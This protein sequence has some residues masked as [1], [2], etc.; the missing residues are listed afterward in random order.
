MVSGTPHTDE[1]RT[2]RSRARRPYQRRVHHITQEPIDDT[3]SDYTTVDRLDRVPADY[4]AIRAEREREGY[5]SVAPKSDHVPAHAAWAQEV[6]GAS[7]SDRFA[8]EMPPA[9]Y[10]GGTRRHMGVATSDPQYLPG[11]GTDR[12]GGR[13]A[14]GRAPAG[15]RQLHYDRYLSTPKQGRDIF[16]RGKQRRMHGRVLMAAAVAVVIAALVKLFVLR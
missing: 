4:T 2:D 8:A 6:P 16:T 11:L 5:P 7:G 14:V 10:R 15:R 12:T 9:D 1:Q 3:A 13:P